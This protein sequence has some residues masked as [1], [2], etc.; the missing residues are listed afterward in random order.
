MASSESALFREYVLCWLE[1]LAGDVSFMECA[2][3]DMRR[4][5][6]DLADVISALETSDT[7]TG[8]K[9]NPHDAFFSLV[10]RTCDGEVLRV[11]IS[12]DPHMNGICVHHVRRM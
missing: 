7:A 8:S 1:H 10:G 3:A 11:T 12:I 4:E 2:F 9:E 6:F 5:G